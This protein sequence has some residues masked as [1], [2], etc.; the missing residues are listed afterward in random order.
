MTI[1]SHQRR[2]RRFMYIGPI[3]AE[4]REELIAMA[5]RYKASDEEIHWYLMDR[6]GE[7]FPGHAG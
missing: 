7:G 4:T 2:D 1:A 5:R 3:S 6:T